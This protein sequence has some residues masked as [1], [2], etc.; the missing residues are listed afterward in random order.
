MPD[1]RTAAVGIAV[2]LLLGVGG[3]LVTGAAKQSDEVL[4]TAVN[5][6]YPVAPIKP[7]SVACQSPFGITEP[8]DRVHFNIGTFGNR[9]P[10]LVVNVQNAATGGQLGQGRVLPGWVDNGTAQDVRVGTVNP[11]ILATVC[12]RNE[13]PRWAYLYGDYYHGRFFKGPL[14]VTPTNSTN[15][16]TVAGA[17]IEGD[18]SMTLLSSASRPLL[19]R[20]G[21]IVRHAATF[22]ATFVH[23]WTFWMLAAIL[24]IGAPLALWRA[25][26]S[27]TRTDDDAGAS[28]PALPSS[29]P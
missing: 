14:G 19:S 3:L 28:G 10:S 18:I 1:R 17:I 12:V 11:G 4:T 21:A 23:A 13:G 26:A 7:G 2:A 24:L 20:I 6:I 25:L 9:G 15:V 29:R 5:P 22:K 16:A 8:F 27:A